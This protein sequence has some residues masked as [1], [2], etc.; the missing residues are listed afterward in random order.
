MKRD[1]TTA[2]LILNGSVLFVMDM[3]R[4]SVWDNAGVSGRASAVA[5]G[6][7]P[8]PYCLSAEEFQVLSFLSLAGLRQK[9]KSSYC[10]T[11]SL[12]R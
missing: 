6:S 10:V 1:H 8:E 12:Q 3:R 11:F 5:S 7:C 4:A 2:S 9:A